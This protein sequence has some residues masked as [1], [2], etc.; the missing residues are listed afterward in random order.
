MAR[1][2][3]ESARVLFWR[4]WDQGVSVGECSSQA[5]FSRTTG[6]RL[7]QAAGVA[8]PMGQPI[9]DPVATRQMI[10]LICR[11]VPVR[12]AAK[13][14]G[15]SRSNGQHWATRLNT[16]VNLAAVAGLAWE[17]TR[18]DI[19]MESPPGYRL[20]P[21]ERQHI[22]LGRAAGQTVTQIAQQI[23]RPK[24]TVSRELARNTTPGGVYLFLEAE[25]LARQRAA[26]PKT[27]K[28]AAPPDGEPVNRLRDWVADKLTDA[29]MSPE[30]ITHRLVLEYPNDK[31]M[32]VCHETIYQA[33]YVQ[34]RG[35]LK[36]EVEKAL[37]QGRTYRKPRRKHS[38]RAAR[39]PGMI[40][41]S[42]RPPE[43]EDR[44]VLGHWEGD[45][46]IGKNSASAVSTLVERVTRLTM[47]GYLPKDH[48]AAS[49][50]DAIVPLLARL[51]KMMR[52]SLT[53]DQGSEMACHFEV[54]DQAD[55]D[56]Y[57]A[58]PHSPWQRGTNENTNGLLRQYMPKGTDLSIHTPEDLQAIADSLNNRPRKV[59]G[60][61]TPLEAWHLMLGHQVIIGEQPAKL[62]DTLIPLA[63]RCVD[64]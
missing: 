62:P 15:L 57:F 49:V 34:A 24:S 31:D 51:P 45:L 8:R 63:Q 23:N 33:I 64:P 43:V 17:D 30:Q 47:L 46:I 35:G 3:P 38:E 61:L 7:V 13:Q 6:N 4:L 27:A 1:V 36:R 41:I 28:L 42:D 20:S 16:G 29:K 14:A 53:W 37:R 54:A 40:P 39:I 26:R 58:D 19:D 21:R 48:T 52:E 12:Q 2:I 32:R 18:V 50:R 56:V 59:L 25:Q 60:W 10:D 11:G 5:G 9:K 55:I 44:A 22:A